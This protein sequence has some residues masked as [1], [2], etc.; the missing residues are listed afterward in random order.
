MKTQ[1]SDKTPS[2]KKRGF[3]YNLIREF[4]DKPSEMGMACLKFILF[5][6]AVVLL[7]VWSPANI[8][9]L[10]NVGFRWIIVIVLTCWISNKIKAY[11][12]NSEDKE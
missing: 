8:G 3:F 1:T 7:A 10:L 2:P 12:G 4:Y 9:N 11:L 6:N 5:I